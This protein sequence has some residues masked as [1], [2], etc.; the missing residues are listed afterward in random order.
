[1]FT[2]AASFM[3]HFKVVDWPLMISDGL[4]LKRTIVGGAGRQEAKEQTDSSAR[5]ASKATQH[6]GLVFI[7]A[8]ANSDL[9]D[10]T[11]KHGKIE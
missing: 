10:Y 2:L 5:Q 3:S 8:I 11:P 6:L 1:M 4:A 7:T 9:F